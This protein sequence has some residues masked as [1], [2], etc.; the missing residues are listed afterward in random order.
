MTEEDPKNPYAVS[1]ASIDGA[2]RTDTTARDNHRQ[3]GGPTTPEPLYSPGQVFFG[4]F[5]GGPLAAAWLMS[6]NYLVLARA[7]RAKQTLWL[8][9]LVTVL[10]LMVA[11]MMPP[12]VPNAIWPI[13]YSLGIYSY[14]TH[15][16]GEITRQHY[17]TGGLKPSSWRVV[18]AGLASVA[19]LLVAMVAFG[20]IFPSLFT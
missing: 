7:E 9:V 16:F 2:T 10:V 20:T 12:Q 15:Q 14:A 17:A 11:F 13:L 4:A 19:I 8:G 3:S 6:R 5:L 1:P 18:G